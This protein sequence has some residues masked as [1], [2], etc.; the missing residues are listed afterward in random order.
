M[1]SWIGIYEYNRDEKDTIEWLVKWLEEEKIPY[2]E[3]INGNWFGYG[4]PM[5][6]KNI[7]LYVPNEYKEKFEQVKSKNIWHI[8]LIYVIMNI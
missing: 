5:Y 8:L 6:Q 2:K 1:E 7:I 3:K 4:K